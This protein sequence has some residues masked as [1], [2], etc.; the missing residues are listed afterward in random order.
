[1]GS[2]LACGRVKGGIANC[3][4]V[5]SDNEPATF[6]GKNFCEKV[7]AKFNLFSI[8]GID[9]DNGEPDLVDVT[10]EDVVP[11]QWVS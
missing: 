2:S 9:V 1:M 6:G 3:V 10:D 4:E 7:F 8:W 11:A 5:P